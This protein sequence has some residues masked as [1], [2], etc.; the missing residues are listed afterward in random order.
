MPLTLLSGPCSLPEPLDRPG[1]AASYC[2]ASLVFGTD[3][4]RL[5][6]GG[7]LRGHLQPVRPVA[8]HSTAR[9]LV[10]RPCFSPLTIGC[11]KAH[12]TEISPTNCRC[13]P[14]LRS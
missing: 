14:S 6:P 3:A 8:G 1:S 9:P 11:R 4:Q 10:C 2:P 13:C 7:R 5:L 12:Q